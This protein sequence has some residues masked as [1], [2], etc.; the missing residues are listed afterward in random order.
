[1]SGLHKALLSV[2]IGAAALGPS[3]C[4]PGADVRVSG[5]V[6]GPRMVMVDG[7]WIVENQPYAVYYA[8][9]FYWRY[10]AAGWY[11][12][13]YYDDGFIS[14]NVG[15]VPR[16]VAGAYRPHHIRYRPSKHVRAQPID[17]RHYSPRSRR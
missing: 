11:R 2:A 16:V 1:M 15:V 8:D 14:V 17:R 10:T 9:G 6:T 7:I 4:V 5:E 13:S 3:A 12:S